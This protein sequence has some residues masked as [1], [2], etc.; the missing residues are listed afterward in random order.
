MLSIVY[1]TCNR[2]EEL[3]KSILSCENHIT[4][5]HE[6]V[7]VDNGSKD[8][9][10]ERINEL[11]EKGLNIRYLL[12]KK[13]LGVAGGRC[14]G[15]EEAYGDVCYF[16]DDDATIISNGNV[17]DDAYEFIVNNNNIFAMGTDCYDTE[18]ECQLVS[19]P[20][21]N[22]CI[23]SE[24]RI[25]N[26]VGCSHFVK[27]A[28]I[29]SNSLYPSNLMYGSEELY[30]GLLIYHMG[31][32]VF[33]YPYLKVLHEP[34]KK[35]REAR[36]E[37]RRHGYINTFV[38]KK[39]YLKGIFRGIS[40]GFFLAR[41]VKFEKGNLKMI[42]RDMKEVNRRYAKEFSNPLTIKE[43]FMLAKCFGYRAII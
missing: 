38:I 27:K 17:L 6:Y 41:I 21:K 31:G 9:T 3:C 5:S 10:S 20:E 42:I 23:N 26:Y 36:V 32:C 13:N 11:K 43:I 8:D 22:C 15:F 2:S 24:S 37:R 34:S 7:I 40:F 1:I 30:A 19:Q 16:I 33:Q 25:L 29:G 39:Y 4:I 14:V 12:Q 18:R 28:S 35:N